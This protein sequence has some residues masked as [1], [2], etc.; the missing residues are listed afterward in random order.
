MILSRGALRRLA[1][2]AS[3]CAARVMPEAQRRWTVAARHELHV[4]ADDRAALRWALG[5]LRTACAARWRDLCLLDRPSVRFSAAALSLCC[6]LTVIFPTLLTLAFRLQSTRL[7]D[8][9]GQMTP[10]DDWQRF[11][12]LMQQIPDWLHALLLAAAVCYFVGTVGILRRRSL[13]VIALLLGMALDL[14]ARAL[15]QLLIAP[16]DVVVHD[17]SLLAQLIVPVGLPLLLSVAAWPR[18]HV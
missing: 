7:L 17:P 11:V 8:L 16:A 9:L 15:G 13:A 14:S 6:A 10:G 1:D 2:A 3:R 4:I 18:P 5:A 12:P